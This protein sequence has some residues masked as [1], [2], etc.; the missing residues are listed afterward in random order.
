MKNVVDAH[1]EAQQQ[2][3][4]QQYG[5][6]RV[7]RWLEEPLSLNGRN[8]GLQARKISK[9]ALREADGQRSPEK[10]I[11]NAQVLCDGEK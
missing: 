3:E 1:F 9:W 5:Q 7:R 8:N 6:R 2:K 11:V 10:E 4:T